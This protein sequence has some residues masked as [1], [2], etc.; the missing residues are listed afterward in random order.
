MA[1]TAARRRNTL[2]LLGGP[3]LA[4]CSSTTTASAVCVVPASALSV[5]A[6]APGA[7]LQITGTGFHECYDT[8]QG[9]APSLRAVP[10][11]F[12]Q[13]GA[14]TSVARADAAGERSAISLRVTVPV[15][16]RPGA[17]TWKLGD[18]LP[19]PFTVTAR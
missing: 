16:A 15:S 6:A 10:V 1:G 17:A 12:E 5:P 9:L 2:L 8:G 4:G 11:V 14:E 19:I 13:G 18:A 3:V 7:R